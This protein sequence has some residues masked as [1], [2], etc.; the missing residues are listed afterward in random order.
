MLF[1]KTP[2]P[3]PVPARY[4]QPGTS[5]STWYLLRYN[6][7]RG[8]LDFLLPPPAFPLITTRTGGYS[9]RLRQGYKDSHLYCSPLCGVSTQHS[10]GGV[11]GGSCFGI[12][13][14]YLQIRSEIRKSCHTKAYKHYVGRQ[15]QH[16]AP[17]AASF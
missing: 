13:S 4:G 11:P 17:I 12:F 8:G 1:P 10:L 3:P 16:S 15:Q 6:E 14:P 2:K 7:S 5:P 9:A